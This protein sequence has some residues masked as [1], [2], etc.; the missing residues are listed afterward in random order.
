MATPALG[1]TLG[2]EISKLKEFIVLLK[3]EQDFL[4][5]GDTASLLPLIDTKTLLSN[6]LAGYAAARETALKQL[7]LPA[8]RSGMEDWLNHHGQT[9]HQQAWQTLLT[10]ASDA[11]E[12]NLLNGKLIGLHMSHNQQA[13]NAL[14]GATD[15]A[16]TYG[17]DGQQHTGGGGRILGKA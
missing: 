7:G 10:L 9:P 12:L 17:P 1:D 4:K 6:T 5:A 14:M 2:A 11:R 3:R 16:M 15:R 8:G 13:F